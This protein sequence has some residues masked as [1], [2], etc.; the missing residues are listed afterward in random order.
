MFYAVG[1]LVYRF[2]WLILALWIV[3]LGV[4]LPFAPRVT[5]PLR[6][7]G[8]ADPALESSKAAATLASDLGYST[9]NVIV[10]Y[11][12]HDPALLATDPRFIA[13]TT[14][15]LAGLSKLRVP[16]TIVSHAANPRQISRDGRT[17][18]EVVSLA[19]D[20]EAAAKLMPAIT[21]AIAPPPDL[22]MR[23]GGGPAFYADVE[24]VS[25]RDLARAEAVAFPIAVIALLL[26][27]GSALAAGLPVLVG[28]AGVV[29]ILAVIYALGTM[30]ELSI[31]TV[32]LAT[33]LGLGLGLDYSLFLSSRFREELAHGH[34]VPEAVARTLAMAG[35]AV[36]YSGLTV[37][38]GLCALLTFHINLL[39]S[40]GIGGIV[41]VIVSVLAATTLLPVLL[42]IVG[43][44]IDAL[45]V[46]KL[47]TLVRGEREQREGDGLW[48]RVAHLVMRHPI[49]VFVPTLGLLLLLGTPFLHIAFSS[50]DASIVPPSVQSRQVYD[51]LNTEFNA[52][53]TTPI[54]VVV[55]T[56]PGTTAFDAAN[57]A[58]LY[59]FVRNVQADPRVTR[60]ESIVSV[61]PRLTLAQYQVYYQHIADLQDPYLT[62]FARQYARNDTTLISII[63][64]FPPNSSQS[65]ALVAKI[66]N[67]TIGNGMT[68]QV[69]GA[70]A[71][72]SDVV[73]G[74]YHSFPRALLFI[75]L[76]TYVVL[77]LLFR[78][79][80]L[81]LKAIA[82]NALS[83]IASYG[84]LVFV[85]QDGHFGRLLNITALHFIEPTLPI[86]MFCTLFGLSMDYEVF[87]L[88]RIKEAYDATGDN[89]RSVATGIERSARIITSA[90]LIVVLV[91]SSF[92]TADIVLV[93][94]LG[95]GVAVAVAVDATVV[96]A[97]L[98]PATMRLLGDW[99]WYAPRWL[100]RFLPRHALAIEGTNDSESP[101]EPADTRAGDLVR[102]R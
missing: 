67:S 18:F 82:M 88:S 38:I 24:N 48:A 61:D 20:T 94:A 2:R 89:A 50:P 83:I 39:V 74:L 49:A 69:T 37:L 97:L 78:S 68:V 47:V 6:V 63:S 8:F 53:E 98:V 62:Q 90:A 17:A 30:M 54:L 33:L 85:F 102:P 95:L 93:K 11:S 87:L 80:V 101:T 75:V 77:L 7:G 96:R 3:V 28:G 60:V 22:T 66:R 64:A 51:I 34:A 99:N 40:I 10:T 26:V 73:N 21:A 57:L 14:A 27:F 5:E 13:E 23:I 16:T 31:F 19:T 36:V 84:L 92:V 45:S 12:S 15:S 46:R 56:K 44:R 59:D 86:I 72:V 81:P 100:L 65:R 58:S 52:S 76:T 41:V 42:S 43:T 71:G 4:A 1:R 25:Q 55:K 29:V 79:V 91:A 32:N 70:T 9:S 35:Q